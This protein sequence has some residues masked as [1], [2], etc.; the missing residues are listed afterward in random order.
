MH[1]MQAQGVIEGPLQDIARSR[2]GTLKIWAPNSN[3]T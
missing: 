3:L 1:I 2:V